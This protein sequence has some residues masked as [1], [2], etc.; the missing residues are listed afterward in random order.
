[1]TRTFPVKGMGCK[2]C[3]ARIENALNATTGISQA[4]TDL[5][6]A[7]ATITYDPALITPEA[8]A[9]KVAEAGYEL[10][11]DEAE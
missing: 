2:K 8:M 4:L 11:T 7:T 9:R 3:Q 10:L 1:M 5:A 6:N